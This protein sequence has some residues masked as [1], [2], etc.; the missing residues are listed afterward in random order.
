MYIN[1]VVAIEINEQSYYVRENDNMVIM[2]LVMS[3]PSFQP[4][5]VAIN[6]MG[7]TATGMIIYHM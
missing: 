2:E 1:C 5:E 4:F 3:Q 6:I 7:I